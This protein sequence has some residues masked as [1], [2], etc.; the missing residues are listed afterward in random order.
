MLKGVMFQY[1]MERFVRCMDA[2]IKMDE[3]A[4]VLNTLTVRLLWQSTQVGAPSDMKFSPW[5]QFILV[6]FVTD[7]S[8]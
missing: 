5:V 2:F 7:K 1:P 4:V 3:L 8:L 6:P